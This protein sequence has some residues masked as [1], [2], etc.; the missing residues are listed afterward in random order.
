ME[1]WLSFFGKWMAHNGIN[2]DNTLLINEFGNNDNNEIMNY[3][4][5]L[6]KY[7]FP[8][9][10]WELSTNQC[11]YLVKSM[12]SVKNK[13]IKNKKIE[14]SLKNWGVE[15]PSQNENIKNI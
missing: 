10:V 15:Y 13:D 3:I 12:V 6:N 9:W 5:D 11:R 4:K 8:S 1:A 7:K 14:T 2:K